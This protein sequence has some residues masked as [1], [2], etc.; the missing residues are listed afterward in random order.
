[1]PR[2]IIEIFKWL[3]S[4]KFYLHELRLVFQFNIALH[5]NIKP[6]VMQIKFKMKRRQAIYDVIQIGAYML[7]NDA[8]QRPPRN[9]DKTAS[10]NIKLKTIQVRKVTQRFKIHDEQHIESQS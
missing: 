2:A 7:K 8:N 3:F 10:R 5:G 9:S 6:F 1:M 4:T